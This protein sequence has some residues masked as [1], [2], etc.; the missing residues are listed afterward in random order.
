MKLIRK[1]R[2]RTA[3]IALLASLVTGLGSVW[4]DGATRFDHEV[5]EDF[6]AGFSGDYERF[7]RGMKKCED[8]LAANPDHAEALV[9]HGSGLFGKS[10]DAFRS[11]D[12]AKGIELWTRGLAEMDRAVEL[13][14]DNIG[15][16]APRG[17]T[18]VVATR[19][20]PKER[21]PE[22]LERAIA[23]YEQ[24]MKLQE[25][26]WRQTGTHGKGE[27]LAGLAEAYDR[28][29]EE[30]KARSWYERV[31]AEVPDSPYGATARQWLTASDRASR[32]K[33]AACQGCHVE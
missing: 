29:G 17:A 32:P 16:R 8:V 12:M 6:F 28:L 30:A 15:V 14:P 9:W 24:I 18:L 4:A 33:A 21:T 19:E 31:L 1:R 10:G 22:L 5:R 2:L 26:E 25:P 20:I 27:L 13:E 7:E 3:G 23:D 11:G